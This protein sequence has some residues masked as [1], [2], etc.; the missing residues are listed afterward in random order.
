MKKILLPV[1]LAL[2]GLGA[3]GGAG[4]FL[5]PAPEPAPEAEHGGEGAETHGGEGGGHAAAGDGGTEDHA[6]AEPH[7]DHGADDH[8]DDGHGGKAEPEYVELNRQFVIP[9]VKGSKVDLLMVLSLVI[10]TGP[11]G[12]NKI[13][14]YE[15][16]LRDEFL[17]VMFLHAQSGG[18]SGSFTDQSSLDDLR[19]A[20]LSSARA[21]VGDAAHSILLT[22]LVR[23]DV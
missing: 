21:V 9:V 4:Y 17:S 5:R 16:K 13:Y 19:N 2:F 12:S 6:A 8:G 11:G 22:N 20:L 3:G 18:F 15:P 7:D 14:A 10:E 1:I 23:Q